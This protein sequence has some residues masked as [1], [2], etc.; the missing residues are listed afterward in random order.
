MRAKL[1]LSKIRFVILFGTCLIYLLM[2]PVLEAYFSSVF[3]G[4]FIILLTINAGIGVLSPGIKKKIGAEEIALLLAFY[5]YTIFNAFIGGGLELLYYG[6][7]RYIFL[8]LPIFAMPIIYKNINW[9][10]LLKALSIF[11][12]IDASCS[13]IEFFTRKALF[14]AAN[15]TKN[16]AIKMSN[17]TI[18]RTYGLNGNYFLL[19]EIL[20]VCGIAALFLARFYHEKRWL[21]A[22]AV[23][24]LGIL[25]TGSRGY[26]IS[27]AVGFLVL[28]MC[29]FNQNGISRK[30]LFKALSVFLIFMLALYFFIGTKYVTGVDNIDQ[31]ITRFRQIV[32][33]TNEDANVTR[34]RRWNWAFQEWEKNPVWGIG[35]CAT[36]TRYSGYVSVAESGLLKRLIELGIIGALLQYSTI[37]IPLYLGIKRYKKNCKGNPIAVFCFSVIAIFLVEDFTLQRYTELE[38][39]IILWALLEYVA[40]ETDKPGN[41]ALI[42]YPSNLESS[43][44][45]NLN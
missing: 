8:T 43:N 35:A 32:D 2:R 40:Y 37:I 1:N 16:V 6:V 14:P 29:D 19:A 4:I 10:V 15:V 22:F 5:I 7:E 11:G 3:K 9:K 13:I 20:S 23:I 38:Y 31:I 34:L 33:F 24:T 27:F 42:K 30:Q 39:T 12:V 25:S 21:I 28:Y 44:T 41:A 45:D 36:D 26:Y 18:I 17:Y